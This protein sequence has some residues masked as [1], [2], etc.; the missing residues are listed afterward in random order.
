MQETR[1]MAEEAKRAT[2]ETAEQ[3]RK[4]GQDYQR[5]AQSGFEAANRVFGEVNR[6]LQSVA[7]EMA[8]C[9]HKNIEDVFRAWEQLVS[10]RSLPEVIDVQTRYAQKAVENYMNQFSRMTELYLDVTRNASRPVEETGR[11]FH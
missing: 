3:A 10:A 5:A 9:T 11:Q 6:G 2:H 8:N 4:V 7:T 1:K